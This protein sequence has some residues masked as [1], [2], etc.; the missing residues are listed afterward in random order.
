MGQTNLPDDV[1]DFPC[2]FQFKVFTDT[3]DR[4]GFCQQAAAAISGITLFNGE[5]IQMRQSSKGTYV[6]VIL[7][8]AVTSRTQVESIYS[9]LRELDGVR[10]LL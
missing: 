6:C 3:S 10:Y 2:D 1:F 8:V 9:I 4:D 7:T 5:N